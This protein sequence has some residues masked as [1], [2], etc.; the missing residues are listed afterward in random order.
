M[1]YLMKLN[2]MF[3]KTDCFEIVC[4]LT[5]SGWYLVTADNWNNLSTITKEI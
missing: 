5:T 1:Y 2:N 3:C 4:K